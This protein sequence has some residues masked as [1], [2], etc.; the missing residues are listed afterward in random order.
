MHESKRLF[1][2]PVRATSRGGSERFART[3][4]RSGRVANRWWAR[5]VLVPLL[6]A[7]CQ[8]SRVYRPS[9]LPPQFTAAT[10]ISAQRVDLTRLARPVSQADTLHPG[11]LVEVTVSTGL[12]TEGPQAF[13]TRVSPQGEVS[14][15]LVGPVRLAGLKLTD[16]EGTIRQVSVQRG[17]Y[18]DPN[19]SVVLKEQ[20]SYRVGVMGEVQEPGTKEIPATRS[21]LFNALAA[22]GGLTENAGTIVE[23]RFPPAS[24]RR[25]QR[26]LRLDL[27]QLNPNLPGI[28]LPDGCVVMVPARPLRA[29]Y[30]LGLVNKAGQYE[31][32]PDKDL[33]LLD[34]LALAGGR[35]LQVADNVRVVRQVPG[36]EAPV[37]INASVRRAKKDRQENLRLA[38]GD[39]VSV[40]ETPLT[41]SIETIRSFIRFGF[42]GGI[43][44]L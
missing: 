19:V 15:P 21:D 18:R 26:T 38:A 2:R 41:F 7:G 36:R 12:D 5:L 3:A 22:A 16:A 43:P 34:A 31:M 33:Y 35:T 17:V 24:N 11:D 20:R 32:P 6:L 40:E 1:V 30:V 8:A 4:A 42:T 39:V 23:L 27:E 44:G 10:N 37:V 14:V 28:E 13:P 9:T 29:V 25:G